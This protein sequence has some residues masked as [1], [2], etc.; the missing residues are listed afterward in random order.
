MEILE[1]L[2]GLTTKNN[3]NVGPPTE[4]V[5]AGPLGSVE[6]VLAFDETLTGGYREALIAELASFGGKAIPASVKAMM[7]HLLTDGVAQQFSMEGRKGKERFRG[8]KL[9]QVI[10]GDPGGIL[11]LANGALNQTSRVIVYHL[12]EKWRKEHHGTV[13][14]PFT[15]LQEKIPDYAA[16]GVD[17]KVHKED[18]GFWAIPLVTPI[19]RRAH[20]LMSSSEA[21]FVD[22]TASCDTARN[23]VTVLLTATAAGAVPIAVMVHNS[24]TTDTYAAGFKLLKDNYPFCFGGFE[25]TNQGAVKVDRDA[26]PPLSKEQPVELDKSVLSNTNNLSHKEDTPSPAPLQQNAGALLPTQPAKITWRTPMQSEDELTKMMPSNQ[27]NKVGPKDADL[28]MD[29]QEIPG[30]SKWPMCEG[31]AADLRFK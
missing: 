22:S 19:I 8:L 25:A 29:E 4:P 14:D 10:V 26:F 9:C 11:K 27:Q 24:Q 30:S 6:A 3:G 12:Y 5:M 16:Q 17:V 7:P 21:I 31:C 15:K 1:S 13:L 18:T 2:H 28:T 20:L 23:T